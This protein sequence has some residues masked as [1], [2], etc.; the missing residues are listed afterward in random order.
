MFCDRIAACKVYQGDQYTDASPYDYFAR[1][2]DHILIHPETAELIGRMLLV[3]KDEGEE[4]AFA[5][6]RGLLAEEHE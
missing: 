5:Y 4:A 2:L 1:S 6:V 3:L